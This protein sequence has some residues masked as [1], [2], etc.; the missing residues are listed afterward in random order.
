MGRTRLFVMG[1]VVGVVIASGGRLDADPASGDQALAE[2]LFEQGRDLAKR[3]QW[4]EACPK[5]EA[6]LR[7][8]NALGA[9]LNLANC[10]AHIGKLA[11][12]W[13]L[14][15]DSADLAQ[16]A[17]D[18]RRRDY[19]LKQAAAL[20][21]RLSTLR[22]SV[23]A[24][25]R[26]G[27]LEVLRD[28]AVLDP[29]T[30]NTALPIDGGRYRISARAP[31]RAEWS[32]G[33]EVAAE[34]HAEAIEIPEL[35]PAELGRSEQGMSERK[36]AGAERGPRPSVWSTKRKLALGVLGGGVLAVAAGG[37]LGI[38]A[39]REQREAH[40]LCPDPELACEAA[41]RANALIRSGHDRALGADVA[42]GVGAAAMI[43]AGMLWFTVAPESRR[44]IAIA[45]SVSPGQIGITA[46]RRF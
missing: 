5:F 25:S 39:K 4:A 16:R 43:A 8:D 32:S 6:S 45:P 7:H 19:A 3:Q 29:S 24:G 23:P 35:R 22:I 15:R 37:V 10:Y 14:Y 26:I 30:W 31:G 27:G 34:R 17:G 42:F 36:G 33:I 11:S 40:A 18:T 9:R 2:R 46:S 44:S 21:P 13:G 12:A 1:A 20:E 41:D 38:S 28:D